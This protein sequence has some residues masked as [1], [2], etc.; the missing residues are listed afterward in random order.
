MSDRYQACEVRCN[1]GEYLKNTPPTIY[2]TM[3]PCVGIHTSLTKVLFLLVSVPL[4]CNN[5]DPSSGESLHSVLDVHRGGIPPDHRVLDLRPSPHSDLALCTFW[6][7]YVF[8]DFRMRVLSPPKACP[9][10]HKLSIP[11]LAINQWHDWV[12]RCIEL[13]SVTRCHVVCTYSHLGRSYDVD[14]P[15]NNSLLFDICCL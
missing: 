3:G 7:G 4:Q 14:S 10:R 2:V 12:C 9:C 13:H 5:V 1:T 8:N 15:Q 6:M 11:L